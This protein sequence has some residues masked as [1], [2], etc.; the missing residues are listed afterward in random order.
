MHLLTGMQDWSNSSKAQTLIQNH[1]LWERAVS[2]RRNIHF[3]IYLWTI[4]HHWECIRQAEPELPA[5][6]LV[7]ASFLG[8]QI[9]ILRPSAKGHRDRVS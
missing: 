6:E 4:F 5:N 2:S 1:M 9:T 8:P 7:S 3:L